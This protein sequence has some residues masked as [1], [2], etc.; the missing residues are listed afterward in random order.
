MKTRSTNMAQVFGMVMIVLVSAWDVDAMRPHIAAHSWY[1]LAF[2]ALFLAAHLGDYL[3]VG[4]LI[5]RFDPLLFAKTDEVASTG[6]FLVENAPAQARFS[7]P[8]ALHAAWQKLFDY[9]QPPSLLPRQT[10]KLYAFAINS[11]EA[12]QVSGAPVVIRPQYS[13]VPI[14]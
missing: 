14:E 12:A 6:L 8:Q 3:T 13:V 11:A 2:V 7:F 1:T 9:Q 5:H 4:R 10:A